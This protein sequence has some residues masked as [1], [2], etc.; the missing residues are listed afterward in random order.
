LV[1]FGGGR[2]EATRDA[3]ADVWPVTG[4]RQVAKQL[5]V[6]EERAH[7]LHVHNVRSAQVRVID[8]EDVA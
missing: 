2:G 3:T 5:T 6:V 7:Q 4:V 8:H 1:D